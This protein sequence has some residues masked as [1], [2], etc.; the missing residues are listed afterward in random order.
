MYE[1]YAKIR[2]I[3]GLKDAD[4]C[5]RAG[6]SPG[7]MSDWKNHRYSLKLDKLK[8]IADA[9][10]VSVNLFTEEEEDHAYYIDAQTAAIAKAVYENHELRVLF[11]AAKDSKPEDVIMVANMLERL[12]ESNNDG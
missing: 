8:K 11:S 5:K 1:K 3:L 6:I 2:D 10:G 4:V 9:L 12:K 7:T